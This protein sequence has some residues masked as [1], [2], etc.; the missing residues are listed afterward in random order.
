MP[1]P[2]ADVAYLLHPMIAML[3]KVAYFDLSFIFIF[4]KRFDTFFYIIPMIL[5]EAIQKLSGLGESDFHSSGTKPNT[6]GSPRAR[7]VSKSEE[8]SGA[9]PQC[10]AVHVVGRFSVLATK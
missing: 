10:R 2:E 4:S 8:E 6:T 9:V 3:C 7:A 5:I 1:E